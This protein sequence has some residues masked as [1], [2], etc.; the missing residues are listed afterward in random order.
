M[1]YSL[2]AGDSRTP[3]LSFT[4]LA[5]ASQLENNPPWV[6]GVR[7]PSHPE[8]SDPSSLWAFSKSMLNIS[9]SC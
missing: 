1:K 2:T 4:H 6:D 9:Q 8:K 3:R 7:P 5:P